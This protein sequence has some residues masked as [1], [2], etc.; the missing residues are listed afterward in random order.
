[1][2]N[3]CDNCTFQ[4]GVGYK[5][6]PSDC[7]LYVQCRLGDDGEAVVEAVR[8]CPHGLYWNQ[9]KLT[10]DFQDNVPC[11]DDICLG[12]KK[13][14]MSAASCRGF[15]DCTSGRAFAKCCA[16]GFAFNPVLGTCQY[17]PACMDECLEEKPH[18]KYECDG[19]RGVVGDSAKYEVLTAGG[20]WV[21]MTC[22]P[23]TIF[24]TYPC[25]CSALTTQPQQVCTPQL[26]LPFTTDAQD[27][28]GQ[29]TW[30][31][32]EGVV[33]KDGKAFFGGRSRLIVPRFSNAWWGATVYLHL[34]FKSLS[35]GY[36]DF[37][38]ALVSNG[39]CEAYPSLSVCAGN[40]GV[41]F[42]ADTT[43]SYLPANITVP[44]GNSQ[45]DGWQEVLFRLEDHQFQG[46]VNDQS[47][48]VQAKG[49]LESRQCGLVMGSGTG[50]HSFEGVMDDVVLYLCRPYNK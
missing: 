20:I 19:M 16:K 49:N 43:D 41:E 22:A 4:H 40:R 45:G 37:K 33:V 50:C 23:G 6:H 32:N 42:Y 39:D 7:T 38:Q 46:Y 29:G 18:N 8:P 30:V 25:G 31:Q 24:S 27:Q 10:C 35:G 36:Y 44:Y 13:T 2:P 21:R 48:A 11:R 9:A 34:R 1:M 17:Q 47:A 28:S 14:K 26:Y 12:Y 3:L 15:W 5:P